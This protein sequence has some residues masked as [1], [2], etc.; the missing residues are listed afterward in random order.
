MS[1]LEDY[2]IVKCIGKGTYCSVNQVIN[3]LDNRK[4]ALKVVKLH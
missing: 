2:Q 3:K 4:Y 1:K